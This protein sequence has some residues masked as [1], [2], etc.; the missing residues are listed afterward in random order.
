MLVIELEN[1]QKL[2]GIFTEIMRTWVK[3]FPTK[4]FCAEK[5]KQR[6]LDEENPLKHAG[7]I[8]ITTLTWN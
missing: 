4:T 7:F 2:H 6:Y 8:A 1:T 5:L 3:D